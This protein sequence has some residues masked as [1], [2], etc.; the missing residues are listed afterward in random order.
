MFR[1]TE[2][3]KNRR[4]PPTAALVGGISARW[5]LSTRMSS[6]PDAA[7]MVSHSA[8][9]SI[10]LSMSLMSNVTCNQVTDFRTNFCHLF[11]T[12]YHHRFRDQVRMLLSSIL[13]S[14][15]YIPRSKLRTMHAHP[16]EEG[17]GGGGGATSGNSSA[18][19]CARGRLRLRRTADVQPF[20][21]MCLKRSLD[22]LP[23]PMTHTCDN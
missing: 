12:S 7:K 23:A 18:R 10:S 19:A 8:T 5:L 9:D 13:N 4:M 6:L 22:I 1:G 3:S 16:A 2:M 17:G 14:C 21:A 11:Q 20:A 15:I